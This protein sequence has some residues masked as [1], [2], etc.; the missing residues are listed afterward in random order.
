[1]A[2]TLNDTSIKGSPTGEKV[3]ELCMCC[4]WLFCSRTGDINSIQCADYVRAGW[5]T[6]HITVHVLCIKLILYSPYKYPLIC[7]LMHSIYTY[8]QN[9][10]KALKSLNIKGACSFSFY[11]VQ[12]HMRPPQKLDHSPA[13]ELHFYF[14]VASDM[15]PPQFKT[16]HHQFKTVLWVV[17]F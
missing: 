13:P 9:V 2:P 16:V 3:A 11:T 5:F 4:R 12:R 1:M 6:Q 15:T 14:F 17:F 7:N 8:E 10:I